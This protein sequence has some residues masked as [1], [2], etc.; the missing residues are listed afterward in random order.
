MRNQMPNGQ[1]GPNEMK[2]IRNKK[3]DYTTSYKLSLLAIHMHSIFPIID[4]DSSH[5]IPFNFLICQFDLRRG[6]STDTT[7][8]YWNFKME[9]SMGS[10]EIS[11]HFCIYTIYT[12]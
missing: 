8:Y 5:S 4:F 6:H 2:M 9:C 10:Y 11:Q 12:Y 7:T 1:N 3:T